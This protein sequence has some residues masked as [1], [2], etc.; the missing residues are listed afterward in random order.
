[1]KELKMSPRS[2]AEELKELDKKMLRVSF[3]DFLGAVALGLGWYVKY[4]AEPGSLHPILEQPNVAL[5]LGIV[6]LAILAW[7][8]AQM[9]SIARRRSE[10]T[11]L[12]D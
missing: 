11:K 2:P 6:G 4:A 9:V 3:I 12:L 7:G 5:G 1:M 8:A 10:L